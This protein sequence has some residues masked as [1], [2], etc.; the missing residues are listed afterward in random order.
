MSATT[1]EIELKLELDP[2]DLGKLRRH[3]RVRALTPGRPQTRKLHSVYYDTADLSLSRQGI[4]LR[5]RRVDGQWVQTVKTRGASTGGL[6]DRG[7]VESAL[8]SQ[9]PDL[10]RIA[11][12]RLRARIEEEATR[13]PL[14]PV[15]ETAF[16]RTRRQLRVDGGQVLFELDVGEARAR[17]ASAPICELELELLEGEPRILF[18]LALEL[19]ES[20]SLRPSSRAKADVGLE[21]LTGERPTPRK[22]GRVRLP[23]DPTVEDVWI[24]VARGCLE[25]ILANERPAREGDDPEGVHQLRVGVRRL[26]SALTLLGPLLPREQVRPLRH[27]LRWLAGELAAARDLDVFLAEIFGPIFRSHR[28]DAD[29]KRLR[30]TARELR[31]HAYRRVK[32]AIGSPRHPRLVLQL[33]RWIA[34]RSWRDELSA[35]DLERLQASA[36]VAGGA[37]L[38]RRVRKARRLG[39]RLAELDAADRHRLRVQLKKLR[40]ACEFFRGAFPE[41]RARARRFL[42]RLKDLQDALGTLNDFATAERLLEEILE[43]QGRHPGRSL[44]GAAGFVAGWNARRE[45]RLLEELPQAWDAFAAAPPFWTDGRGSR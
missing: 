9:E 38:Q 45:Q 27:E 2:A 30:E 19:C 37:L 43:Q 22:A 33:G 11:D 18:D 17:G 20:V 23:S 35:A 32:H 41:R 10:T 36:R 4:G 34:T 16:A 44:V 29:L 31:A 40:Y 7:E 15:L 28:D 24:A 39:S 1:R 21:L 42:A 25:Q 12:A 8:P 13:A 3:P 5:V 26:R 6:F 14:E